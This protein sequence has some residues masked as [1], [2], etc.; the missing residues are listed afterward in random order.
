MARRFGPDVTIWIWFVT[1]L[2]VLFFLLGF[3]LWVTGGGA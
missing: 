3:Y 2:A 1:S